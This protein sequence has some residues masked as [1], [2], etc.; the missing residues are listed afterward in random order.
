MRKI[1]LLA[2]TDDIALILLPAVLYRSGQILDMKR[3]TAEAHKRGIHIG[4]DLCHSIGAIPH[5]FQEWGVDFAVWCNYKYLNAGP[6][7]VGGLY[8]N[9]NILL[10]CPVFPAGSVQEKDKQFDME[11]TLTAP[12]H[13]GA[14]Q[15]GTPHIFSIAPLIGS[16]EIFKE[17]GIDRLR[18]KSLAITTRYMLHLID[19]ELTDKGFT[20]GNPLE[21]EKRGGHIYLEHPEVR[22]YM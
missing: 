10:V 2:M 21:D 17:A 11:H 15:I 22:S 1:L 4:F 18:Q 19:Y 13:A 16:L 8:V 14:Y 12:E 6:G 7:S 3:L 20:I 5:Q 9:K